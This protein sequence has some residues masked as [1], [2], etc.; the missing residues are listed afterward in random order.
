MRRKYS[1][2]FKKGSV[3]QARQPDV[4]CSQVARKLGIEA[5]LFSR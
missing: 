2:E 4:S 3:E 1:S 5:N